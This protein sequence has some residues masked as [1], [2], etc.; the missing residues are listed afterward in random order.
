MSDE[1]INKILDTIPQTKTINATVGLY[2]SINVEDLKSVMK[3]LKKVP[4]PNDLL[5]ENKNLQQRID[6]AIEYITK[7]QYDEE[8]HS[9]VYG[10]T[11]AGTQKILSILKGEDK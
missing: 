7:T 11:Y 1:E 6:K 5:R 8:L 10:V 2:N 4:N 9:H 3:R